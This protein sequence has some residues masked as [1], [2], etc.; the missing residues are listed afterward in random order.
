MSIED[1]TD[2]FLGERSFV[3]KI[4]KSNATKQ[5][6]KFSLKETKQVQKLKDNSDP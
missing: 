6:V 1:I 2:D 5:D 3:T 4:R